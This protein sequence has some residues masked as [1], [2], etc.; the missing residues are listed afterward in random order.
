MFL[1]H[2]PTVN[3]RN[4]LSSNIWKI[5]EI[6]GKIGLLANLQREREKFGNTL[7]E[8]EPDFSLWNCRGK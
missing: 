3:L 7:G 2:F 1:P 5:Y 4:R 8:C 6:C